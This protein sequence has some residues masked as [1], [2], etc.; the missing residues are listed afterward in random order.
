MAGKRK[1]DRPPP[2][3]LAPKDASEPGEP[4]AS[5]RRAVAEV[6]ELQRRIFERQR[7]IIESREAHPTPGFRRYRSEY[8]RAVDNY[9]SES[10]FG[11]L[12]DAM[13]AARIAYV[14]DYHTLALAQKTFVKI[15]ESVMRQVENLCLVLEFVHERHQRH[16]DRYLAG[17]L[18]EDAFLKAIRY[19][20]SWP[21]DIWPNFK[22]I[23]ELAIE[24][25][26]PVVAIDSDAT[27]PLRDRDRR[28]ASHIARAAAA[29]P[30]STLL[31]LTGQMHV[32][33]CHLPA[34][35][36]GAFAKLGMPAP[37]R[38][39]VYQNAEE[40]YWQ[41]ARAGREEVEVVKVD[42]ESFCVNN[43]PPLVQ[44]LSYLHWIQ[45]DSD[46]LEYEEI[47]STVRSLIHGM[48]RYLNLPVGR[49]AEEARVLMPGDLDLMDVLGSSGLDAAGKGR[50]LTQIELEESACV[51][52]LNLIYLATLS[53]N[54]AAEEA[55][56]YVKHVVSRGVEP[57]EL[58]DAFYFHVLNEACGFFG[59]KVVNPKRKCDHEGRLRGIVA[60]AR[61]RDGRPTAA[62][63]AAEFSLQHLAWQGGGGRR[64]GS[65]KALADPAVL[66]A[67]A[68]ML[69]YILG[70]RLYYGLT[71]G[72]VQKNLV[73]WLFLAPL[74]KEREALDVY[75]YLS[76]K[77]R[78]VRIPTR[79]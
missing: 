22:P 54:H 14:A 24:N 8:L 36:D 47:E 33:P 21:Y 41:L 39:V 40:I 23:F 10:G 67:A 38:V 16:L 28:A 32:A 69:G 65:A 9:M 58:R 37:E 1:G 42:D 20:E 34:A 66:A 30:E 70:D 76:E 5:A 75:L 3:G 79:I 59:S 2:P 31:V 17:E 64:A 15:V 73:R 50:I 72:D 44:Q 63:R 19:K 77:L 12:S 7:R 71:N 51:P 74:D 60:R 18:R 62:E 26:F 11:A 49:A 56:H 57:A 35:V 13:A 27:L 43:T 4:S 45:Y 6:I 55:S 29:C 52:S 25:G 53:V 48:A 61:Q 68:H 78:G 46:L